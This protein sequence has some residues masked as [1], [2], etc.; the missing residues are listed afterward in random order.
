MVVGKG[1]EKGWHMRRQPSLDGSNARSF[2]LY[3]R[4]N[5]ASRAVEGLN[6]REKCQ[7]SRGARRVLLR[8]TWMAGNRRSLSHWGGFNGFRVGELMFH[9]FSLPLK[10]IGD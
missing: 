5:V 3:A 1:S 6:V 9:C 2:C 7:F 10:V 4:A 8:R